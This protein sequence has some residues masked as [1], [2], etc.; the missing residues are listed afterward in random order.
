MSRLKC[1]SALASIKIGDQLLTH[2][3]TALGR[4]YEY[5]AKLRRAYRR[6]SKLCTSNADLF[7]PRRTLTSPSNSPWGELKEQV[8]ANVQRVKDGSF[9]F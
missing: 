1:L 4:I 2:P 5:T 9:M 3:D 6:R 7:L 8:N